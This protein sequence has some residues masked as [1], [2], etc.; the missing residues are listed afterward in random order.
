MTVSALG[1]RWRRRGVSSPPY[2]SPIQRGCSECS[3]AASATGIHQ[4]LEPA[5]VCRGEQDF[6]SAR[7]PI[8]AVTGNVISCDWCGQQL[9]LPV[10][11]HA[12]KQQREELARAHAL[13][14]GWGHTDRG[15]FCFSHE[16]EARAPDSSG[17]ARGMVVRELLSGRRRR[18]RDSYGVTPLHARNAQ[19]A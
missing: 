10:L 12:S 11:K 17:R 18:T 16:R 8:V 13:G 7:V 19:G 9:M 2:L 5:L 4:A 6:S 14:W 15:D 3:K 1:N